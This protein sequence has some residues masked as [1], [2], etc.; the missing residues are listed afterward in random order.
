MQFSDSGLTKQ[1]NI[2]LKNNNTLDT[3]MYA[4]V[5][6]LFTNDD[7][8]LLYWVH[9]LTIIANGINTEISAT[10]ENLW[11]VEVKH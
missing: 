5:H 2:T 8:E 10:K 9:L 3:L 11:P 6:I 4:H 1:G 7:D